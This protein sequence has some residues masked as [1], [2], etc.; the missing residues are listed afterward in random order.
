[1]VLIHSM[2]GYFSGITV[3]RHRLTLDYCWPRRDAVIEVGEDTEIRSQPVGNGRR[4]VVFIS[5]KGRVHIG[6]STLRKV[7]DEVVAT[8]RAEVAKYPKK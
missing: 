5:D 1:M 3:D 4:A 2:L 8:L 6:Q 7:S